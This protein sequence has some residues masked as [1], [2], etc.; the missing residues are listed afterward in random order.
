MSLD[1]PSRTW[2]R[3]P[4]KKTSTKHRR[5]A[6]TKHRRHL[7]DSTR[8][9]SPRQE[10]SSQHKYPLRS[11]ND[12]VFSEHEVDMAEPSLASVMTMMAKVLERVEKRDTE[13]ETRASTERQERQAE[14]IIDKIPAMTEGSDLE[15][16]LQGLE[17][18]FTQARIPGDRWK[19]LLTPWLTPALKD[20][21][22]DLQADPSSTY[23]EIKDRL[24]DRVG[25]TSLQAGQQ[26]FELRSKDIR[27]KSSSQVIQMTERL[28]NR[29]L[30]GALT[31]QDAIVKIGIAR[32]RS[33]MS[34]EGQQHLDSWRINSKEDL[35]A[36]LQSWEST[37][38]CIVKDEQPHWNSH[39]G[40]FRKP[41]CFKCQKP[42]HR[43]A[44]CRSNPSFP[45]EQSRSDSFQLSVVPEEMVPP[46][47]RTGS[48]VHL[49][50]Y[51]GRVDEAELAKISLCVGKRVWKGEAAL[52]EGSDLDGKGILAVD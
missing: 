51:K 44:E 3:M 13:R 20:H 43:A 42:G 50:G 18:E 14:K 47:A 8:N 39:H 35:R 9:T 49:K 1:L 6:S 23:S 7:S 45:S 33:L 30:R 37:R 36:A 17:N 19:S 21:I 5:L 31:V 10:I 16:Y 26:L 34:I 52:V 2:C 27:E 25:Q 38:G 46:A 41:V 40:Q 29:A 12:R 24:L 48:K 15:L 32:I 22:G 28:I 4:Y 11:L